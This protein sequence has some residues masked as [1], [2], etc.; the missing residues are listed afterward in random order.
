MVRVNPNADLFPEGLHLFEITECVSDRS[1]RSGDELFKVTMRD[2]HTR[3]T[4]MERWM[5][6]GPGEGMTVRK[7]KALG[8][9]LTKDIEPMD[10]VGLRFIGKVKHSTS[11]QYGD[12]A[13]I[14]TIWN[15]AKPPKDWIAQQPGSPDIFDGKDDPKADTSSD[16]VPW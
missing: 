15:E 16:D 5:V 14:S 10:L 11:E 4:T 8:L 1:K 9:D 13:Q 12:Q 2:V 7:F 6:E 3:R